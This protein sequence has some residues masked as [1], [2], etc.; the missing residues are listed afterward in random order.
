MLKSNTHFTMAVN[1]L[2][3]TKSQFAHYTTLFPKWLTRQSRRW[4]ALAR[5]CWWCPQTSSS[6]PLTWWSRRWR[7]RWCSSTSRSPWL[8]VGAAPIATGDPHRDSNRRNG[9]GLSCLVLRGAA[10]EKQWRCERCH[11]AVRAARLSI[12]SSL[13]FLCAA[14]KVLDGLIISPS[15]SHFPSLST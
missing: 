11:S 12:C 3:S 2:S 13:V 5:S 9:T 10:T 14:A 7:S 4:W 15:P 1:E 8:P 6:P